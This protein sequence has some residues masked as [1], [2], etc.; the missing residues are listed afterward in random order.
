MKPEVTLKYLSYINSKKAKG[1]G[2]F[3][4]I[5]LLVVVIIIG[6]LAAVALPNLL[7]QVGKARETEGK[8]GVGTINRAQ[9]SFHF[10]KA[11]FSGALANTN[12]QANNVLGV[13]LPASKYY[14]FNIPGTTSVLAAVTALGIDSAGATDNGKA[15]GTRDYSGAIDFIPTT[16]Q[17]NQ[18]ICQANVSGTNPLATALLG[19]SSS[20]LTGATVVK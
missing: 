19:T 17:Y 11:N 6:V 1:E 14:T 13:I 8:T 3:T 20:C 5:E 10:E 15:Q 16:G 4:L 2:G 18:V 12:L 7:N 9:Q